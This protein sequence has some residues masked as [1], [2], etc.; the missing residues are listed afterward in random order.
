V[1]SRDMT[2]HP[3][4]KWKKKGKGVNQLEK[5]SAPMASVKSELSPTTGA[6]SNR[7]F[8]LGFVSNILQGCPLESMKRIRLQLSTIQNIQLL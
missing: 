7:K 4:L 3:R 8:V 6:V 2:A 5:I 1:S